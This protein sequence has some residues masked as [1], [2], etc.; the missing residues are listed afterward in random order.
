MAEVKL[1]V[2]ALAQAVAETEALGRLFASRHAERMEQATSAANQA[3]AVFAGCDAD[4]RRTVDSLVTSGTRV[5]Q[6]LARSKSGV[7]ARSCV[8]R[9]DD[10]CR[11]LSGFTAPAGAEIGVDLSRLEAAF[12]S[13]YTMAAERRIHA[14]FWTTDAR[15]RMARKAAA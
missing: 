10:A 8:D 5:G 2:T 12:V 9:M 14:D 11:I 3:L 1:V 4:I 15:G 7:E 6:D 13:V